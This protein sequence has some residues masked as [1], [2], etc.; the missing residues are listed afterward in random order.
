MTNFTKNIMIAAAAVVVVAGGASAQTLKAEIPFP[1]Q[2]SGKA[3]P[4]G[5]Y[6]VTVYQAAAGP[7]FRISSVGGKDTVLL[8]PGAAG[9]PKTAWV[10]NGMPVLTF[11]CATNRCALA[12]I[13]ANT[14]MR[15]YDI[16][17][18]KIS[19]DEVASAETVVMRPAK[20]E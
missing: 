16:P 9:D 3:L 15:A 4:A 7:A 10:A 12:G 19:R 13:W 17:H 11:E 8:L 5:A 20:S 14:S 1:F 2:A 18:S 6:K